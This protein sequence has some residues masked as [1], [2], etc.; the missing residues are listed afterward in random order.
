[1][2]RWLAAPSSPVP[3]TTRSRASS[4][5]ARHRASSG[6]RRTP[7]R[8]R[9]SRRT[10]HTCEIYLQRLHRKVWSCESSRCTVVSG[11]AAAATSIGPTAGGA[12]VLATSAGIPLADI[13]TV[14]DPETKQS[15]Y[16]NHQL[17]ANGCVLVVPQ[18]CRDHPGAHREVVNCRSARVG[19]LRVQARALRASLISR[20]A[21][22]GVRDTP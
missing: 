14:V 4:R 15:R 6:P 11:A 10:R 22:A 20:A 9:T 17:D 3:D 19:A 13:P 1:M 18:A 16:L 5:R 12:Y 2:G 8:W 21:A 7:W